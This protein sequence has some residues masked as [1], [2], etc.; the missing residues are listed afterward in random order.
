M[1]TRADTN[2]ISNRLATLTLQME[3]VIIGLRG[4]YAPKETF[5]P[6]WTKEPF[7]KIAAKTSKTYCIKVLTLGDLN[8]RLVPG[9]KENLWV[10]FLIRK[11]HLRMAKAI[12]LMTRIRIDLGELFFPKTSVQATHMVSPYWERWSRMQSWWKVWRS[13]SS[14][15]WAFQD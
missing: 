4:C 11:K 14:L 2:A 7:R 15:I 6:S 13:Y 5:E 9:S 8:C 10:R 12:K 1:N 3:D